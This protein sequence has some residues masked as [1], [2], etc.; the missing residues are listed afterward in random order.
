MTGRGGEPLIAADSHVALAHPSRFDGVRMLR[1]G[2]NFVDGSD[3]LGR[4]D[5]GLFFLAYQRDIRTAF[6]PVQTS[7][8]RSDRMR[9]YVRHVGS[10]ALAVP[11][12]LPE[13][14]GF[15]RP[16]PLRVTARR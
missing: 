4:L 7:L 10:A 16:D 5:A 12:G 8:A 9:E 14:W 11:P 15:R 6:L 13:G 2:Y 3:S 1:R